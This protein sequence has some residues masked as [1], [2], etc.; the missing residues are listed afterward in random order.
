MLL[1]IGLFLQYTLIV[2]PHLVILFLNYYS[3]LI[4]AFLKY[5]LKSYLFISKGVSYL[6]IT[7]EALNLGYFL[8]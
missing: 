1:L 3:K 4:M 6:K 7:F 5:A 8:H 2:K